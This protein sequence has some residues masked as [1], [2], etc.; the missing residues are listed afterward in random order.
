MN[1]QNRDKKYFLKY[2]GVNTV[3][4]HEHYYCLN[5]F[6][7]ISMVLAPYFNDYSDFNHY[8]DGPESPYE[9]RSLGSHLGRRYT[10]PPVDELFYEGWA[11]DDDS[12]DL[13]WDDTEGRYFN[14]NTH[15]YVDFEKEKVTVDPNQHELF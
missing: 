12:M 4:T 3:M 1:L 13:L 14:M 11:D 2:W 8:T 9:K 7:K 6:N 15:A 5:I 10:A